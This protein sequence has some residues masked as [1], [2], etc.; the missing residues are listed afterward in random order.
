MSDWETEEQRCKASWIDAAIAIFMKDVRSELR[1]RSALSSILLFAVTALVVV[2]FSVGIE[3]GLSS[4]VQ[5]ALL[6]IVLFFAAFSG[7]S[8]VFLH[9]EESGT[10]LALRLTASPSAI[11]TGKLMFNQALLCGIAF[12]VA[13]LYLLLLDI[14]PA[15]LGAFLLVILIGCPG[16]G[17]AA[18][19]VAA[20][21]SRAKGRG[22]LYGALG[23]PLLLPLLFMAVHATRLTL[24]SSSLGSE[25]PHDLIGLGAFA[26]MVITA[27]AL[28]FPYIWEE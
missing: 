17:A 1:S 7:L 5:A 13:P 12:L 14:R 24:V 15:S 27:G 11:Y 21:I 4:T 23:F 18:T 28:L 2:G 20:I 8:H 22:A 10:S 3:S 26:V 9:E 25:L 6:W 19:V 16:L